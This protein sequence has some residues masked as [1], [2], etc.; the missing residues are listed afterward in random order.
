MKKTEEFFERST[1]HKFLKD[2]MTSNLSWEKVIH[3]IDLNIQKKYLVKSFDDYGIVI[4]NIFDI[5]EVSLILEKIKNNNLSCKNLSAHMYISLSERSKTFGKHKDTSD[6]WF[7]QCIG[8]TK[9]EIFESDTIY[10]YIL[11]QGDFIY[12]PRGMFHK[13]TPLSPRVGISFGVDSYLTG[14][15]HRHVPVAKLDQPPSSSG[16]VLL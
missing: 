1:T 6:V 10:S 4:H 14:Q 11:K 9:W 15:S 16:Q 13:T 3:N 5:E 8:K 2:Y 12:V 7:W